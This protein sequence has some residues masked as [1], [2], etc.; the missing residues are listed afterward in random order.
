MKSLFLMISIV[1]CLSCFAQDRHRIVFYNVENLFDT[2]D[3]IGKNDEDFTPRGIK[4]WNAARYNNKLLSLARALRIAGGDTY[5][6]VIGMAEVEN[7]RVLSD[8]ICKTS[9]SSINYSIVHKESPDF[10]GI[11]VALLYNTSYFTLIDSAFYTVPL[12]KTTTTRD[13]L[14]A[15]GVLFNTDTVNFFVCHFPSRRGGSKKSAW[16][17]KKAASILRSHIDSLRNKNAKIIIMGDLNCNIESEELLPLGMIDSRN[18]DKE[19][20]Y[21]TSEWLSNKSYGTYK[22][23]D[24]WEVIDHIIV[25]SSLLRKLKEDKSTSFYLSNKM[26]VCMN[27]YLLSSDLVHF[28]K[29]PTPTYRGR[30][31]KGGPSDHL[32]VYLDLFIK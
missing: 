15:K 20:L 26:K 22:Y 2:H 32:P 29:Y 27:K 24:Y 17:R 13:I 12:S 9:L 1:L 5:P 18:L 10:R 21:D 28:G 6:L 30:L 3:E 31:Y 4:H 25:S 7:R 14:Y 16:K 23:K 8:L 19:G 11:D